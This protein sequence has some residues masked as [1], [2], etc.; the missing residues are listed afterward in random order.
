MLKDPMKRLWP[1]FY[2]ENSLF[3]GFTRGWKPFVAANNLQTG[4]VC[5][6]LKDI[7]EDELVYH[8]QFTRN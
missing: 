1:V 7:D 2:H 4:D 8:V 3:V 5:V 6:L